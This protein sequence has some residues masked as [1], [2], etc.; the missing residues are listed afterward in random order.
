MSPRPLEPQ[1]QNQLLQPGMFD[2]PQTMEYLGLETVFPIRHDPELE[3]VQRRA[4]AALDIRAPKVILTTLP[5]GTIAEQC[6][7]ACGAPGGGG[8]RVA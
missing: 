4:M 1:L 5:H 2:P 6:I 8:G 7:H 3:G